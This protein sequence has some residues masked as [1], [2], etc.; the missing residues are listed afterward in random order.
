[1]HEI[2]KNN[3]QTIGDFVEII[4]V[5]VILVGFLVATIL[6]L[7]RFISRQRRGHEL[8]RYYRQNL[9]RAILIG[10]EFLVAGDIIRTVAGDLTLEGVVTLGGVVLIRIILGITLEAELEP[11]FQLRRQISPKTK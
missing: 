4:G 5:A 7:R 10:L 9:A 8:F 2:I 11:G 6:A 3:I 1:M